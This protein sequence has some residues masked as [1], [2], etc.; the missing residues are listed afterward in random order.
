[1]FIR[2]PLARGLRATWR[3]W[4]EPPQGMAPPVYLCLLPNLIRLSFPAWTWSLQ[5][6]SCTP[7][8]QGSLLSPPQQPA[9]E[10]GPATR[11]DRTG[12]QLWWPCC[13]GDGRLKRITYNIFRTIVFNK[14]QQSPEGCKV[15]SAT[16]KLTLEAEA[17]AYE[18]YH[19]KKR[20]R[21]SPFL[22]S[23]ALTREK[24]ATILTRW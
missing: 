9:R 20:V 10:S 13:Y 21:R 6:Q 14:K 12:M 16:T 19:K 8:R 3:V 23:S 18:R 17:A 2:E 24:S 11:Q 15:L 22:K 7:W 4:A 1:M 5:L